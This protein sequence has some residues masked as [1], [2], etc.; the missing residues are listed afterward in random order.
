MTFSI[1]EAARQAPHQT[2]LIVD[3]TPVRFT[4]LAAWSRRAIA[5]LS[6]H[7]VTTP[8]PPAPLVGL[9]A[10][11]TLDSVAMVYALMSM[12]VPFLPLHP[13]LGPAERARALA[14]CDCSFVVDSGWARSNTGRIDVAEPPP[15]PDDERWLAV[16]LTSGS[17]GLPKGVA[18]GRR[19]FRASAEASA[20]NLGWQ[21]D[22]RWLLCL[23]YSHVGGL[24]VLTRCLQ[25]RR[26]VVMAPAHAD[27]RSLLDIVEQRRV[28]LASLV[29]AQLARWLQITPSWSPPEALRAVLVGGAPCR[30]DLLEEARSRRVPVLCTYGLTEACSQVCTQRYGTS[31]L[32]LDD[33]GPPL[34]GVEVACPGDLIHVRG[35]TLLSTYLPAVDPN[36]QPR[37][38][39][40]FTGDRGSFDE[41]GNLRVLGRADD[42]IITGGQNVSAHAVEQGVLGCAGVK[43]AC[44]VPIPDPVWGQLIA[45]VVVLDPTQP[46]SIEEVEREAERRL[47]RLKRP[48]RWLVVDALPMTPNGKVD[49][50]ACTQQ[51]VQ[52]GV[53]IPH[54]P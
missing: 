32:G 53:P 6:Q 50:H 23:P 11:M 15:I 30:R 21:T 22:D 13:E 27:R 39:W 54:L 48:R 40:H 31:P 12:G 34:R 29:P 46:G 9:A 45:A 36:P 5:W 37:E 20:H 42:V 18:L 33:C 47:G 25:A 51:I 1:F 16:V 41:L 7:G 17:S 3:G 38:K 26:A 4:D 52:S 2:A 24:S 8:D 49:R 43:A 35:P 44:I 19:A 28:T 14:V 10:Q